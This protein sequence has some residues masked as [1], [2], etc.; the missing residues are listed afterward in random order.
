MAYEG[1]E[2]GGVSRGNVDDNG[3]D[4]DED[5]ESLHDSMEI[6]EEVDTDDRLSGDELYGVRFAALSRVCPQN[7]GW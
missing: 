1:H 5:G 2:G 6:L 4:T 3:D 7:E